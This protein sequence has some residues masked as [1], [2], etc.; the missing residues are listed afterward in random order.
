MNSREK[1]S[2]K[3]YYYWLLP[4]VC[5]AGRLADTVS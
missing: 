5:V 4:F 1:L 2:G 3:H